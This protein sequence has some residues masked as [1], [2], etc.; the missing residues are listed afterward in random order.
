MSTKQSPGRFNCYA[1]AFPDE[2]I[3]T[4]LARDPAL[5][6]TVEFW[7]AERIRLGK[8][9][10]DDDKDRLAAALEESKTAAAWREKNLDPFGDGTPTWRVPMGFSDETSRPISS[11]PNHEGDGSEAVRINRFWLHGLIEKLETAAGPGIVREVAELLSLA[12]DSGLPVEF[13][14]FNQPAEESDLAPDEPGGRVPQMEPALAAP[15]SGA[16]AGWEGDPYRAMA[17]TLDDRPDRMERVLVDTAPDDLAHSPEVPA[18]RFSIFEKGEQ[19]AYARGLEVS[20]TH[21]PLAL[22]AMAKSGWH[23]LA[24]FGQTDAKHVGFIFERGVPL[25]RPDPYIPASVRIAR[26]MHGE[27]VNATVQRFRDAYPETSRVWDANRTFPAAIPEGFAAEV[28]VHVTGET[29]SVATH[30]TGWLRHVLCT[31][32]W[33]VKTHV[34]GL[35][36]GQPERGFDI[37]VEPDHN[38]TDRGRG[39][40]P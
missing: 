15:Y 1:A 30:L 14:G 33:P 21:L 11:M 24:I 23:L 20:P 22:D 37:E 2:T 38:C 35:I 17:D 36:D 7:V 12:R 16:P 18:H 40:E 8:N 19:Y 32:Q 4:L 27:P 13:N 6:A 3:F 29:A 39:L 28:E 25:G 10:T 26:E 34:V 5:P 31:A 9:E